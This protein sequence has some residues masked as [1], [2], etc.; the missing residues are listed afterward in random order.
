MLV[1]AINLEVKIIAKAI[2]THKLVQA[3]Y[4]Y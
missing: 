2:Y 1:L 4:I 3:A